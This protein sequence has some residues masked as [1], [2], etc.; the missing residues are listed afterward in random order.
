MFEIF[1]STFRHNI[2]N[3]QHF[4]KV[5][6]L[7]SKT[8]ANFTGVRG[9]RQGQI[10]WKSQNLIIFGTLIGLSQ[11]IKKFIEVSVRLLPRLVKL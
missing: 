9:L 1:R 4:G 3:R 7:F 10:I 8:K 11:E 6:F 5:G 2:R